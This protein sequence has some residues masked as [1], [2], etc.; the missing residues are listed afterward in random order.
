MA[1]EIEAK[2]E[3]KTDEQSEVSAA[4]NFGEETT[5]KGERALES[6][7]LGAIEG[8]NEG[9]GKGVGQGA[10]EVDGEQGGD[11][12]LQVARDKLKSFR[13][14]SV[15]NYNINANRERTVCELENDVW[16]DVEA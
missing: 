5:A 12:E 10:F 1:K 6:V 14:K 13:G 15:R 7:V 8:T 11:E 9:D 3:K 16:D 4:R 2:K